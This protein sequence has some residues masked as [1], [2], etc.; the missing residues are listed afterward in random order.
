[1]LQSDQWHILV[2]SDEL[3]IISFIFLEQTT[4]IGGSHPEKS[5]VSIALR[6]RPVHINFTKGHLTIF[7]FLT[8]CLLKIF[9]QC[10]RIIDIH[11]I[12]F[13]FFC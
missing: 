10:V 6:L 5:E 7:L 2:G 9:L 4:Q 3:P 12:Y 1:M 11:T 13:L 8:K